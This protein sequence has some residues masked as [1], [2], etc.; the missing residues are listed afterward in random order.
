MLLASGGEGLAGVID[1]ADA[2]L[3]DP[4]HDFTYLWAFGDWAPA[5]A[6]KRY[7]LADAG[8]VERSRW[9]WARY[10]IDQLRW[11]ADGHIGARD[12][13]SEAEMG[14]LFDALGV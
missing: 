12:A 4:A 1:F 13:P 3:D 2:E 6:A 14:A 8:L 11:A 9:S 10:R 5:H 7:G